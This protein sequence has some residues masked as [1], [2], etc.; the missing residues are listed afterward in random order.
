MTFVEP[1]TDDAK[2][3]TYINS[4][5]EI[6]ISKEQIEQIAEKVLAI[7]DKIVNAKS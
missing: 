6:S 4:T 5:T 3:I 2:K 1:T 7:R